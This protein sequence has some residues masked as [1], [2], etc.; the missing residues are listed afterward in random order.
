M[1]IKGCSNN[2]SDVAPSLYYREFVI[3]KS[4]LRPLGLNV[5][6]YVWKGRAYNRSALN[7]IPRYYD[8]AWAIDEGEGINK[9]KGKVINNYRGQ[10]FGFDN[11]TLDTA[12]ARVD[13][14]ILHGGWLVFMTHCWNPQ[15]TKAEK[16]Q[17]LRDLIDFI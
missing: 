17:D 13:E 12:K 5:N 11:A 10:W 16:K 3:S 8:S 14:L 15:W 7:A 6:S 1:T 4:Y 2:R 9:S